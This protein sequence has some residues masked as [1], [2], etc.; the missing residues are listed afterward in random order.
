MA[1]ERSDAEGMSRADVV[2]DGEVQVTFAEIQDAAA[3]SGTTN[4]TIQTLLDDLYR[5]IQP[6]VGVWTGAAA[7]GF[8]YQHGL[9]TQAAEDLNDV[10]GHISTLLYDTHEGY[11]S[12]E[13]AV[14]E[15]WSGS[16]DQRAPSAT[17]PAS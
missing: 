1:C 15:L 8:Q 17:P 5:R 16:G 7:E 9:W 2:V 10:L 12:A 3:L 11:T 14:T 6:I 13:S 4:R